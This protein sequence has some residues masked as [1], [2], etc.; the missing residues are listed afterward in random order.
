[1]ELDRTKDIYF[2]I[3]KKNETGFNLNVKKYYFSDTAE[4][5]IIAEKL[6]QNINI[7][8]NW[9]IIYNNRELD[10]INHYDLNKIVKNEN[11]YELYGN[12][13]Y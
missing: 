5:K 13:T 11:D 7:F 2:Y 4:I 1:M 12:F 10:I 8:N 3:R 6:Q 9:E